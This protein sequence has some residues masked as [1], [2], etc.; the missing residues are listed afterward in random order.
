MNIS[1]SSSQS[2]TS[3]VWVTVYD[4]GGSDGH[5]GDGGSGGGPAGERLASALWSH[6]HF[7]V[8]LKQVPLARTTEVPEP[9]QPKLSCSVA[10]ISLA[11]LQYIPL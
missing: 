11:E 4:D 9:V 3:P 8:E 6:D 10:T 5:G 1:K 2:A 7:V